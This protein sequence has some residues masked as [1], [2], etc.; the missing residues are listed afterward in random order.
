MKDLYDEQWNYKNNF[1]KNKYNF[2]NSNKDDECTADERE[3]CCTANENEQLQVC[4]SL[5]CNIRK[6]RMVRTDTLQ[7][8]F[9]LYLIISAFPLYL[10]EN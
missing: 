7:L 2:K 10:S 8:S 9:P 6:V 4:D 1:Q 3:E 5:G